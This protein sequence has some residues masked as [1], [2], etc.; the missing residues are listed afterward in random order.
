MNEQDVF[1]FIKFQ[2]LEKEGEKGLS[3]Y[4]KEVEEAVQCVS[5]QESLPLQRDKQST[6]DQ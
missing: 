4:R 6:A 5:K 3:Q 2:W 1:E